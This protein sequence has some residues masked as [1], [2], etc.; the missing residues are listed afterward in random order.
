[1]QFYVSI[2]VWSQAFVERIESF[3]IVRVKLVE[4]VQVLH[5]VLELFKEIK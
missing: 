1:M 3:D 2:K 5:V 4:L